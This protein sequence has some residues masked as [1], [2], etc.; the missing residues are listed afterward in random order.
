MRSYNPLEDALGLSARSY[1]YYRNM[2]EN[3][4]EFQWKK[5][6][7]HVIFLNFTFTSWV[8]K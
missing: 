8:N 4:Y 6:N 7:M 5:H 1:Y 3:E 2:V